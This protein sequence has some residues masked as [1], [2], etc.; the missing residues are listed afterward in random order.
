M[1]KCKITETHRV[2]LEEDTEWDY[3]LTEALEIHF[4]DMVK[5]KR[6]GQKDIKNDSLDGAF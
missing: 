3:I 4:V 6:M 1:A 5:F 2:P